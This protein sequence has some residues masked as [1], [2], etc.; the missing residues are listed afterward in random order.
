MQFEHFNI[1]APLA[2][3]EKAKDFYIKVFDLKEGFRP[4]FSDQGTWLYYGEQPI[5]HLSQREER[6]GESA[7]G[8][9]DHLAFRLSGIDAFIAKLTA[10]QVEHHIQEVPQLKMQQVFL[11]DPSGIKLEVNFVNES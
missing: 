4:N 6:Q 7:P 2:L 10:L 11:F 8:F 3:L 1:C 9:L 5:L